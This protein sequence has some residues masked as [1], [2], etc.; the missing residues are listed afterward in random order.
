MIVVYTY[1][2]KHIKTKKFPAGSTPDQGNGAHADWENSVH[3]FALPKD[4]TEQELRSL[5]EERGF[6]VR[7]IIMKSRHPNTSSIVSFDNERI[8]ENLLR[9]VG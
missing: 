5:F 6:Q 4:V 3:V 1:I 8:V 2:G 7:G 9:V